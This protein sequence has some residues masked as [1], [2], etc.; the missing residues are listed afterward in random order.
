MPDT[1]RQDPPNMEVIDAVT[2][3]VTRN[4][5]K[6]ASVETPDLLTSALM[7]V[8]AQCRHSGRPDR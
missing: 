6:V 7:N 5:R 3:Y 1:P 4:C 8:W 2:T